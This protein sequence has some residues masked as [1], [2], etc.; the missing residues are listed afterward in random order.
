MQQ[1]KFRVWDKKLKLIH[2]DVFIEGD[3]QIY[4]SARRTYDTPNTE[5]E[6]RDDFVVMQFTGFKDRK[7]IEIYEGDIVK[8]QY[9]AMTTPRGE[10]KWKEDSGR[11]FF[12]PFEMLYVD[13][14]YN[15]EIIGNIFE[16]PNLLTAAG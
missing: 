11:W 1:I 16:N 15:V 10:V 14:M 4:T 13:I 12:S 9:G 7:G 6:R 8:F 2:N 5:I 3:G